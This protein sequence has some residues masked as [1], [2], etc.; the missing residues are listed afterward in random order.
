VTRWIL[1]GLT[2]FLLVGSLILA[3]Q[4]STASWATAAGMAFLLVAIVL[5]RS[6]RKGRRLDQMAVT[7]YVNL[8]EARWDGLIDTHFA[9]RSRASR[10]PRRFPMGLAT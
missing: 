8:I 3:L 2:D 7:E 10:E 9:L 6:K 1:D 5:G 4:G